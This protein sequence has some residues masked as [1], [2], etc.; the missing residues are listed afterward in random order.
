MKDAQVNSTNGYV[1]QDVEKKQEIQSK[2]GTKVSVLPKYTFLGSKGVASW[3]IVSG[4]ETN[5]HRLNVAWDATKRRRLAVCLQEYPGYDRLYTFEE[6]SL[7][8][9]TV[10]INFVEGT[11]NEVNATRG[12]ISVV[13][14]TEMMMSNEE[15]SDRENN[16]LVNVVVRELDHYSGD[17]KNE[18][19]AVLKAVV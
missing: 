5:G 2:Q 3:K 19:N 14:S 15:R 10:I 1:K 13:A 4:N 16:W 17:M 12:N 6:L 7:L 9:G 11:K 18:K 8:Q